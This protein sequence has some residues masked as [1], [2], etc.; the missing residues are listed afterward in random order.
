MKAKKQQ[1]VVEPQEP[2]LN[3][4]EGKE[5]TTEGQFKATYVVTVQAKDEKTAERMF[6]QKAEKL[7]RSWGVTEVERTK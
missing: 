3:E 1:P 6:T 4:S 2:S 7:L 5:S